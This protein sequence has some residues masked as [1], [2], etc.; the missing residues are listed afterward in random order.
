[1]RERRRVRAPR[2]GA[3]QRSGCGVV[4]A[5]WREAKDLLNGAQDGR[6]RVERA[7]DRVAAEVRRRDQQD[8]AMRVYMVRTILRIVF[9]DEDGERWPHGRCGKTLHDETEG[10]IVVGQDRK[11]TRLNSSH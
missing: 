9:E 5:E 6:G 7:V 8:R 4:L 10:E 3:P 2:E 1:M 11:S